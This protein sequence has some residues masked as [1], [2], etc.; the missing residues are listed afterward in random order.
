[1]IER[2][3]G[4]FVGIL[5]NQYRI[6]DVFQEDYAMYMVFATETFMILEYLE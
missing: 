3:S 2:K 4:V 1:M 6:I 5:D